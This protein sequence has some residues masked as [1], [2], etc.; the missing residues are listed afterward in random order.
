MYWYLIIAAIFW[1]VFFMNLLVRKYYVKLPTANLLVVFL[2]CVATAI[3]WPAFSLAVVLTP[4]LRK[5]LLGEFHHTGVF[6]RKL[7][8]AIKFEQG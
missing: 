2:T 1:V 8:L 3:F 4:Q 5:L 6:L 7:F